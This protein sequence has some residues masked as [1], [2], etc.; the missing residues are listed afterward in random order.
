M[1]TITVSLN[2]REYAGTPGTTVLE[3]ARQ[4][5]IDIPTLCN[6][7]LLK[8]AGACRICLVQEAKTGRLM[9]SCVTPISQGMEILTHS[10]GAIEGRR[11]VLELILSDHP[12]ACVIC[13]KGNECVLRE[14]AKQHGICDPDLDPLRRW[15]PVEEVNPFIVRDHTK[16]VLCG[17]CVRVCKD[18]EA[19][20]AIEYLDRGYDCHPGTSSRTPL[21]GSECNFCG[22]CVSICPTDA[23]APR[24]RIPISSGADRTP[25]ICSY[26]GTGCHME[27]EVSDGFVIGA[28]GVVG[29]PVNSLSLCVRGHY[30]QDTLISGERL[31][32]P[33]ARTENGSFRSISWSEALSE[34][35]RRLREVLDTHGPRSVAVLAGTQCS[36][37]E[38]YL[39]SRFARS[40]LE[41][42]NVDSVSR[43]SSGQFVQGIAASLKNG[44][45][46][47]SLEQIA[48]ADTIVLIGA[49]PDYT[50]PVVARNVRQAVR[51][52][53]ADLI[54]LDPL[55]TALS[56]FARIHLREYIHRYPQVLASLMRELVAKNLHAREF[57]LDNTVH[58]SEFLASIGP[59]P[60]SEA[61]DDA[62]TEAARL[63][64]GGRRVVFL[65]GARA[66]RATQ[67]YMITRL[68]VDLAILCGQ[69]DGI[70]YLF[71]GC[72]EMGSW[73]MGC[74]TDS[75]PGK[76]VS[77]MPAAQEDLQS[78]WGDKIAANQGLD[79]MEMIRGAEKGDVKALL[80]LGAD[81]LA[82]FPD[83]ERTGKALQKADLVIRTGMFPSV[84]EES[85][86]LI[87][88]TTALPEMDGTYM[89]IE[90]RVQKVSRL[91]D[92]P[93]NARPLA[94][95]L[96][97]LAGELDGAMRFLT[98]REIFEEMCEV[99]PG[100]DGL[101]WADLGTPGGVSVLA[102]A[103]E[104]RGKGTSDAPTKLVPYT[105]P[106]S[107]S[108]GPDAPPDRPFRILP[109]EQASHPGDGVLSARSSRLFGFS[110][111]NSVRMNPSDVE[112]ID[113]TSGD[114]V[115]LSS[116]CGAVKA[117]LVTD[118][119]V[120][121]SCVVIPAGGPAYLLHKLLPWPEEYC[122]VSWDRLFVSV[123]RVEE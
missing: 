57:V 36:N 59:H 98:A 60:G 29:T 75:L 45:P 85:A 23:L 28:R 50:N 37:E 13:N 34:A 102:L 96:L 71:E 15:R 122:P 10:P 55:V 11:G 30:G 79:A 42:P 103:V 94:R 61:P 111:G 1:E 83:P 76:L 110:E 35:A 82:V 81:P 4:Q 7:P 89:N 39:I 73:E 69:P 119:R 65:M 86:H 93:G 32:D 121:L 95:L 64:G 123:S 97:D 52:N 56:P 14:L 117:L 74:A 62:I 3:L 43:L 106:D 70:L 22:S 48:T 12:S 68:A 47:A 9:A 92:P 18:Y 5:G 46:R 66:T 101:K 25:G 99:C 16:C 67:G 41:T 80:L 44:W 17:R 87:F 91:S 107:F 113:V 6:H 24:I 33:M 21:E 54:Q 77:G 19:V 58:S 26:C 116:E 27:Y 104:R 78:V 53:G 90:A 51:N 40:V 49:R 114:K 8:T 84:G 105:P 112:E 20:G 120:P 38:M 108:S 118:S 2:G 72:N 100:W 63:I 31:T 115:Q 88:P 109:E